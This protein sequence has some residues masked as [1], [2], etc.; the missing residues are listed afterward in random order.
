[1]EGNRN[2]KDTYNSGNNKDDITDNNNNSNIKATKIM[3]NMIIVIKT[4]CLKV[5]ELMFLFIESNNLFHTE[6]LTY[7]RLFFP[8]VLAK[9]L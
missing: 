3:N 4:L 6:G 9:K 2:I 1:M 5:F 7:E 8:K